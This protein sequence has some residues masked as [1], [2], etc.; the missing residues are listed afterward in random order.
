MFDICWKIRDESRQSNRESQ[1]GENVIYLPEYI[2]NDFWRRSTWKSKKATSIFT[3]SSPN[4]LPLL[5]CAH[6]LSWNINVARVIETDLLYNKKFVWQIHKFGA[7]EKCVS[8]LHSMETWESGQLLTVAT[9]WAMHNTKLISDGPFA[10]FESYIHIKNS[11]D[12]FFRL[13]PADLSE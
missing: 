2:Q 10:S 5:Q 4:A 12:L 7:D 8:R 13:P 9:K 11:W 1:P 6:C 3:P